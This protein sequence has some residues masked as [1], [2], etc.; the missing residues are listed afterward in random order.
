MTFALDSVGDVFGSLFLS[1]AGMLVMKIGV[2]PR[3]LGWLSICA[4]ILLLLQ[5]FCVGGVI[6]TF[7]RVLDLIGFLLFLIFVLV[8]SVALLRR[9]DAVPR[10]KEFNRAEGKRVFVAGPSDQARASP[11]PGSCMI[12]ASCTRSRRS[13]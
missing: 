8:S 12:E 2:L 5:G 6:G 7:G 1:V 13:R 10:T 11:R 3:W 9:G 4:G